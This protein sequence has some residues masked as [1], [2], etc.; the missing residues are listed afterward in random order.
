MATCQRNL[1][2]SVVLLVLLLI[3]F[4]FTS[5]FAKRDV[6]VTG[7][8]GRPGQK[9][10]RTKKTSKKQYPTVKRYGEITTNSVNIRAGSNINYEILGKLSKGNRVSIIRKALEWYEIVLP[11]GC[12]G[13]IHSDYVSTGVAPSP[14]KKV[15]GTVTGDSVRIRALPE[16]RRSVLAKANK[17]DKVTVVKVKGEWFGIEPTRDCTGWVSAEYVKVLSR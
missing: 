15:A 3:P 1:R 10:I 17:G 4:V 16:L 13:W 11:P 7:K 12:L 8:G 6:P 9:K 5:C 14:G 2:R